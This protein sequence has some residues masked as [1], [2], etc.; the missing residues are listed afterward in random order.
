MSCVRG[1][2]VGVERTYMIHCLRTASHTT[3]FGV[4]Q[5]AC[6]CLLRSLLL[7]QCTPSAETCAGQAREHRPRAR[8]QHTHKAGAVSERACV[9]ARACVRSQ[10]GHTSRRPIR[11]GRPAGRAP[12]PPPP[13]PVAQSQSPGADSDGARAVGARDDLVALRSCGPHASGGRGVR[14]HRS[15]HSERERA[16]AQGGAWDGC[17]RVLVSHGPAW[18]G[19]PRVLVSHSRS[20][21]ASSR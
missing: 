11:K 2:P 13:P 14:P 15:L 16:R 7:F 20:C 19:C 12:P 21:V 17:P 4:S 6:V 10:G 5:R 3:F 9:H 18:D 8:T 1:A